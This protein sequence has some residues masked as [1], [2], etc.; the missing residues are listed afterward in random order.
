MIAAAERRA[1]P[2]LDVIDEL[3]GQL[4]PFGV[5]VTVREV[6]VGGFSVE[7]DAPFLAGGQHRFRFTTANGDEIV[8]EASVIHRRLAGSS[9]APRY[10]TG[11]AFL[12]RTSTWARTV[13]ALLDSIPVD[14]THNSMDIARQ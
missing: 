7:T 8:L 2:R 5:P 9:D 1:F 10:I 3:N 11:F 6:S 13:A 14:E 12:R 4:I